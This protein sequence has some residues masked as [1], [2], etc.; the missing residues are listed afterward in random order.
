MR[1]AVL[2]QQGQCKTGLIIASNGG[3]P[4]VCVI[5]WQHD[6]SSKVSFLDR[7]CARGQP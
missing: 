5:K 2:N 7:F 4:N 1:R 6:S 3:D